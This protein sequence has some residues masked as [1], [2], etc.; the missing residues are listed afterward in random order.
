MANEERERLDIN[1]Q[2]ECLGLLK[3]AR[4]EVKSLA[5]ELDKKYRSEMQH[6]K[7]R[8]EAGKIKGIKV[9]DW[10]YVPAETV[11]ANVQDLD[12]FIAWVKEDKDR[13]SYLKL[14]ANKE[15]LNEEV[16]RR[17]DDNELPIP[18]VGFRVREYVSQRAA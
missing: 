2:A 4:D 18:G 1:E 6:L 14:A 12:E 15:A 11:Y 17:L 13:E 3:E 16:R 5:D 7:D 10:N 9:G 8:M